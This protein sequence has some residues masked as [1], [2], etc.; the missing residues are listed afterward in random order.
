MEKKCEFLGCGKPAKAVPE[1]YPHTGG[2]WYVCPDH[3]AQQ[4]AEAHQASMK[5]VMGVK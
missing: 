5:R 1:W 4:A 3:T 2:V